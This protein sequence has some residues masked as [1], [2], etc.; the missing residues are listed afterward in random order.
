MP[1]LR[2]SRFLVVAL[3]LFGPWLISGC[4]PAASRWPDDVLVI[5]QVAEPRSLD[6]QVATSLNDFRILTNIYEG[7]VRFRD[8]SL[9]PEPALAA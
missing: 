8:G 4:R 2:P 7:L 1:A 5:G 6:P 9:E 3:L